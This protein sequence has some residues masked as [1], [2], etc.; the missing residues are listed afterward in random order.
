MRRALFSIVAVVAALTVG[1]TIKSPEKKE[2]IER[3]KSS[4]D[5]QKALESLKSAGFDS[6]QS[7]EA[8]IVSWDCGWAGCSSTALVVQVMQTSRAN[9]RTQH[10][11]ALVEAPVPSGKPDRVSLIQ[12]GPCPKA[13]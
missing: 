10:V 1:A 5:V 9:P 7:P 8:L 12:L 11:A 2:F 3:F 6:P 13:P 4:P